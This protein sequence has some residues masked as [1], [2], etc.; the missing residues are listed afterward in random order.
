VALP[1]F[2]CVGAAKAGTTSLSDILGQHPDIFLPS[3]KEAHFF[4]RPDYYEK[5][6]GWYE[7]EI[8]SK[9][10]GQSAIGEITPSYL[11]FDYVPERIFATLGGGLKF[12]FML[13]NP[14]DRAYSHYLMMVRRGHEKESFESAIL[15]EGDRVRQGFFPGLRFSYIGSGMY[16]TQIKRYLNFFPKENM[17]FI[18]FEEDFIKKRTETIRKLLCF[19]GVR[20]KG[21]DLD[22]QR[23][24]ASSPRLQFLNTLLFS[25]NPI[26]KIAKLAVPSM[27]LRRS[28]RYLLDR[29]NQRDRKFERLDGNMKHRLFKKYFGNEV[30]ELEGIIGRDLS[31]WKGEK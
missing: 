18:L 19:L 2:L 20:D 24:A 16:A 15:M 1:N 8:F 26:K 27:N 4:D 13:R 7:N 10:K 17:F 28:M 30:R 6:L 21:F 22:I 12:I 11:Y 3:L 9:C 23:N 25:Q 31:L 5:G 29:V 14:V